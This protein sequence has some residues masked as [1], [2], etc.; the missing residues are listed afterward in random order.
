MIAYNT[1]I[2]LN[3]ANYSPYELF[4]S[5]KPKLLLD[6]ETIP[7]I[8]GSGTFKDYYMILKKR[9]QY[10]YKLLRDFK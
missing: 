9:L 10:L 8:K 5:R 7:D 4:F 3:L 2:S 1:F 6:L